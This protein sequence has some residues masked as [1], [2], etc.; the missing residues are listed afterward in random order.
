MK[1][2]SLLLL[3]VFV[4]IGCGYTTSSNLAGNLRTIYVDT[5]VNGI[6]FSQEGSR[7][8]YLPLIEVNLR[9]KIVDRFLFDGNLKVSK[10][11]NADLIL[12]GKLISYRKDTLRLTE[13][14][15]VQEYR[16]TVVVSMELL[17]TNT[18][19]IMWSEPN[20]GGESTYFLEGSLAI[21]EEAAAD[22]AMNDLAK[23][24]VERTIENW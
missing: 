16:I 9:N 7:D 14:D 12:T 19:K 20:F 2:K 24:I 22:L 4:F 21:S 10:K 11:E 23:R 15:N 18:G 3:L 5:F 8:S 1:I 13:N 6:I 17:N